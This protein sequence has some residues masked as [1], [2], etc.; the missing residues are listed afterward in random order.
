MAERADPLYLNVSDAMR[1]YADANRRAWARLARLQLE[2]GGELAES[3]A[4]AWQLAFEGRALPEVLAEESALAADCCARWTRGM[5]RT[6]EILSDRR[7][8]VLECL[9]RF[10]AGL[11]PEAGQGAA[12]RA[13]VESRRAG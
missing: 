12:P 7:R 10:R 11:E 1:E 9:D 2:L 3:G 6:V 5:A 4:R 8:E 13:P